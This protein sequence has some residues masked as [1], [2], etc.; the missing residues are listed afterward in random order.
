MFSFKTCNYVVCY[1]GHLVA[2]LRS[3]VIHRMGSAD[4]M[5]VVSEAKIRF[6]AHCA[7]SSVLPADLRSAVSLFA[8]DFI[9][10]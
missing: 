9:S 1:Q 6:A 5:S 8:A 7:G 2:M 3:L 4:N 10:Y